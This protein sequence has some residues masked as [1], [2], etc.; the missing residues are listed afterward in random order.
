MLYNYPMEATAGNW[1]NL[2]LATT[3]M[4]IHSDVELKKNMPSWP[5][6]LPEEYRERL[7]SRTGLRD[8]LNAY[9][10]ALKT[11][12]DVDQFRVLK[13]LVQQNQIRRLLSCRSTCMRIDALPIAIHSPVMSL[14]DYAFELLTDLGV[15]DSHYRIIYHCQEGKLCPF[16]GLEYFDAPGAPREDDDHYLPK[17]HYPFAAANLWN[18]VPA[19]HKCNSRYKRTSDPIVN[20]G[21]I[22]RKAVD[23]YGATCFSVSLMNSTPFGAPNGLDPVWMVEFH[24]TY[25]EANTW[26]EI[27]EIRTR[28]RRDV[29]DQYWESWLDEFSFYARGTG[30]SD[31]SA[32]R[33][34]LHAYLTFL[35]GCGLKDRAFLKAAFAEM[36]LDQVDK[37]NEKVIGLLC[38]IVLQY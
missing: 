26:D 27:F 25:D 11:L 29:L 23:P 34:S 28:Y 31:A 30:M 20:S 33:S 3:L 38:R 32:L 2:C 21:G 16:C 35:R 1:L 17:V 4:R 19:G 18:L 7:K 14:F 9:K 6:I 13:A 10:K 36:L 12:A 5:K 15:R 8:R 37:A 24:P 22:S